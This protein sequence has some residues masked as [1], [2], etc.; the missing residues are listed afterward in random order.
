MDHI[1][2]DLT[3]IYIIP[4]FIL[5]TCVSP[6]D[7]NRTGTSPIYIPDISDYLYHST[8]ALLISS[9]PCNVVPDDPDC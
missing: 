4:K 9:P 3:Q 5:Y 8:N 2:P 1:L 7:V 6:I